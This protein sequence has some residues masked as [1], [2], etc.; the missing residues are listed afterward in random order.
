VGKHARSGPGTAAEVLAG[1]ESEAGWLEYV[2]GY[3]RLHGWR[4]YHPLRSEG[5]EAGWPDLAL[6]RPPVLALAELKRQNGRLDPEQRAWLDDLERCDRL[7]IY[8]TWR[9]LDRP[10]VHEALR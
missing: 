2:R 1:L 9:P 8:R 5:S 6:C 7:E 10:A 3:A 4:T